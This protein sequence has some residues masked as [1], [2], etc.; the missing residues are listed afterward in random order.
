MK[1]QSNTRYA[2]F[3]H[4]GKVRM[5]NEDNLYCGGTF[6]A[7]E[8]QG[9]AF[10]ASG[11]AIPPCV[12]AV[13]DGMG[14]QECGEFASLAAA[15][16]L[17]ELEE[18]IKTAPPGK[19]DGLVQQ[20]VQKAN[21]II[22]DKMRE[23]SARIGTTLALVVITNEDIRPYNIGDS[24]I[25]DFSNGKL[26]QISEDH[27]LAGQK[28]N[29][30]IITKEQ[31]RH[32]RDRNKLTRYLG[33]FEDEMVMEAE[34][35]PALSLNEPRRLLLC[36]DGLTDLVEDEKI[37]EILQSALISE[38]AEILVNTALENG[39]KDNVTCIVIDVGNDAEN[40]TIQEVTMRDAKP[41]GRF[42]RIF[43]ELLCRKGE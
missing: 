7:P 14:G 40:T 17:S 43:N 2:Y 12:F 27:T 9:D 8:M 13:C 15:S 20:Y 41:M 22:C 24:R 31:A 28:V 38:A 29:M 19:I 39:G 25:Y 16:A 6:I 5:N 1:K 32:D 11:E 42:S 3:S 34:P 21:S 35:L 37:K 26:R 18:S 4:V 23:K 33:I 36:S 10:L 30:G